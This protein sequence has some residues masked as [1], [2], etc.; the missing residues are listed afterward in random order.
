MKTLETECMHHCKQRS[1]RLIGQL[2]FLMACSM[3][4]RWM[5]GRAWEQGKVTGNG[6]ELTSSGSVFS[7]HV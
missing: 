3:I 4:K 1:D 7:A 2:Q 5:V 6:S